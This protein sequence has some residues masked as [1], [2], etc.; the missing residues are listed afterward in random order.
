MESLKIYLAGKMGRLSMS[1]MNNWRH[2]LKKQILQLAD[3]CDKNVNVINP[4]DYYNFENMAHQNE[5]EVMQFDIN[6]V[7]QCDLIIAKASGLNTS[8]GTS[9]E[10]YEASKKN[11][12]VLLF[13]E[14]DEYENIHPWLKCCITR[15]HKDSISLIDYIE[16]FYL[17]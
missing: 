15:I 5:F 10:I 4:V 11:I 16:D 13:D 7:K 1:A 14:F 6:K 8:I 12:P 3:V 2:Y 17:R 9:I